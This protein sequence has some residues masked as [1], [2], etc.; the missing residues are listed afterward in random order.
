MDKQ[1]YPK[2]SSPFCNPFKIDKDGTRDEV[3][4]KYEVYIKEKLDKDSSLK[5]ELLKMKG[6]N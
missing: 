6:K 1:R 2:N 5:E 3:I 4:Q